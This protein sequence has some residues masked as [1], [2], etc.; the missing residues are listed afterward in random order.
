MYLYNIYIKNFIK[1]EEVLHGKEVQWM[2]FAA[3]AAVWRLI[4]HTDNGAYHA[5]TQQRNITQSLLCMLLLVK[6]C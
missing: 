1:D 5:T 6:D 4:C 2:A 3:A